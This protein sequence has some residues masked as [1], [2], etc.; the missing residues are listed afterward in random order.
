MKRL[1]I[2]S[3]VFLSLASCRKGEDD[4]FLSFRSRDARVT[5]KWEVSE[6]TGFIVA[7][8]AGTSVS[9]SYELTQGTM[10]VAA[11]P[12]ATSNFGYSLVMELFDDGRMQAIE[13]LTDSI[14]TR[15]ESLANG[16]WSWRDDTKKK[17]SI[18]LDLPGVLSA[19]NVYDIPRLTKDELVLASQRTLDNTDPNEGAELTQ[20]N[21]DV[22]FQ[23]STEE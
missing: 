6:F 18:R 16:Y 3:L 2:L 5:Q 19:I 13:T 23:L 1:L 22:K 8:E 9:R 12:G 21:F 4:P 20:W 10:T 7:S 15:F 17:A 11:T 14:G